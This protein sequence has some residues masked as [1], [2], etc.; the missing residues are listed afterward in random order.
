MT[1]RFGGFDFKTVY[2]RFTCQGQKATGYVVAGRKGCCRGRGATQ[3][4]LLLIDEGGGINPPIPVDV[5]TVC[6]SCCCQVC[7]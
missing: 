7:R 5:D 6:W 3:V 4:M 1:T 2:V